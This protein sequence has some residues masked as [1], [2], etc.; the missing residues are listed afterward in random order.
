MNIWTNSRSRCGSS[1]KRTGLA[2]RLRLTLAAL[3]L[4]LAVLSVPMAYAQPSSPRSE[5]VVL[6][7][8]EADS[9]L[10]EILLLK[11]DLEECA[12]QA[13]ADSLY[14]EQRLRLQERAYEDMLEAYKED[15]PGW[16]ERAIK[17]P[18]LWLALGM[19]IGVQA[20]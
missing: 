2:S 12:A 20:Q 15:R 5:N 6:T 4:S 14:Q 16:V 13:R 19:W 11:I 8:A 3:L 1:T 9:V 7:P 10:T 17:Q 18:V